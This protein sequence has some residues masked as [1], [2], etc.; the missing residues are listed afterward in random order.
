MSRCR[1]TPQAAQD[2]NDI[3]DRIAR[4]SPAAAGRM[5]D[6][7]E[8]RCDLLAQF[9]DM[10]SRLNVRPA[11]LRVSRITERLPLFS[12]VQY[13]EVPDSASGQRRVSGAPPT[14][15]MRITSAPS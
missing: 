14:G 11:G 4:D 7:L 9:P 2:L 1:L 15:S 6:A 5:V 13:S 8:N 12:P 3:H 10:G